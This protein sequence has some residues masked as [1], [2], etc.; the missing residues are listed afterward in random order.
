MKRRGLVFHAK[1]AYMPNNLGYCGPD[2]RGRILQLIEQGKGGDEV[3][4]TLQEFEAAYPFLKLIARS[5]GRDVYDA[6]VPE[7]Y[8]IGND[9]LGQVP[10]AEFYSFSH[11]ELKGK[12]TDMVR[13]LFR[14]VDGSAPPH[15]TFYVLSTYAGS[16]AA[17][18]QNLGNEKL[19]KLAGLIDNCRVS[20]GEVKS[21]GSKEL[22]VEWSPLVFDGGRLALAPPRMKK[23][24]YNPEVTPFGQVKAGD[25]VSLHWNYACEVLSPRQSRNL[26]GYTGADLELVNS[27]LAKSRSRK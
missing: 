27:F 8:W 13:D 22:K 15:H 19:S 12:D 16:T 4:R 18:G 10:P 14:K 26:Q 17:D 20:W 9:L 24:L 5:T 3:L 1:H 21:V 7:A 2:D 25:M 23:V 6:A 11:R